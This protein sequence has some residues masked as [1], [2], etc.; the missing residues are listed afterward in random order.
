MATVNNPISKQKISS[1]NNLEGLFVT[2]P[3]KFSSTNLG[4]SSVDYSRL[5]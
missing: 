3:S 5:Q 2:K 4:T 1:L